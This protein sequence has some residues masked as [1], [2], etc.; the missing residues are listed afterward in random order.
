MPGP[1]VPRAPGAISYDRDHWHPAGNGFPGWNST[2]RTRVLPPVGA[3]VSP[4]PDHCLHGIPSGW[5][6]DAP[7]AVR[8]PAHRPRHALAS[9]RS[10]GAVMPG[11]VFRRPR[12][13][14]CACPRGRRA[15]ELPSSSA[16]PAPRSSSGAPIS[17]AEPSTAG[18]PPMIGATEPSSPAAWPVSAR[19][20]GSPADRAVSGSC[21]GEGPARPRT[22]LTWPDR[23]R[24]YGPSPSV[25]TFTVRRE[26]RWPTRPGTGRD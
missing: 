13:S 21:P 7:F 20:P 25:I 24:S 6:H 5:S 4:G 2:G 19:Y 22:T 15:G 10:G 3:L 26:K 8:R 9:R 14:C 12:F 17:Q 1:V 11:P 16:R 23:C 18:S